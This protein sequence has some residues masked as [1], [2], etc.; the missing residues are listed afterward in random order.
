MIV[1]RQERATLLYL[2]FYCRHV[3][4][5]LYVNTIWRT[6]HH[7]VNFQ[8]SSD[9]PSVL[10]F[11]SKLHQTSIHIIAT[12]AKFIVYDILHNVRFF[13]LT[14]VENGCTNTNIGKIIFCFSTDVL[15]ALH[16]IT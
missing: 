14:V 16:I 5:R 4:S 13:L 1:D 3:E 7:K 8:L 6:V 10:I 12:T 9:K 15:P 11:A 2:L